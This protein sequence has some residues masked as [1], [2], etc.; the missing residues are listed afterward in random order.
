[1]TLLL[2]ASKGPWNSNGPWADRCRRAHKRQSSWGTE[3]QQR[4]VP[5]PYISF[6]RGGLLRERVREGIGLARN[7]AHQARSVRSVTLFSDKVLLRWVFSPAI[8]HFHKMELVRIKT[9]VPPRD[10]LP[11]T[12]PQGIKHFSTSSDSRQLWAPPQGLLPPDSMP[13]NRRRAKTTY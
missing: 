1:M 13:E 2:L 10:L 8:L 4:C 3:G 12:L 6:A 5:Y 7:G 11:N 9:L